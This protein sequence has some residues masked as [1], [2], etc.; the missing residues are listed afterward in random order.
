MR[1]ALALAVATVAMC[2]ALGEA[3]AR[4]ITRRIPMSRQSQHL[5]PRTY[6]PGRPLWRRPAIATCPG[7]SPEVCEGLTGRWMT[8]AEPV[9]ELLY[10]AKRIA[11]AADF[12]ELTDL[13]SAVEQHHRGTRTF[14][15][16]HV[17]ELC[18]PTAGLA[19]L[20]DHRIAV[21]TIAWGCRGE[22]SRGRVDGDDATAQAKARAAAWAWHDR[23][24]ALARDIAV[25][26]GEPDSAALLSKMITWTDAECEEAKAYAALPFPRSVDMPAPLQHI[27]LAEGNRTC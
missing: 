16:R 23:R 6:P 9:G 21:A 15:G 4:F 3:V 19:W 20:T 8:D 17:L 14:E 12:A 5:P 11:R 24:H 1:P 26:L 18:L 2:F 10:I 25:Q 22:S 13:Q 7:P 27:L